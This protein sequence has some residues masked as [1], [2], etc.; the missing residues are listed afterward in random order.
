MLH[1]SVLA[2]RGLADIEWTTG[3]LD[4]AD[5]Q[6]ALAEELNPD[7]ARGADAAL[8]RARAEVAL[9]RNRPA[10]ALTIAQQATTLINQPATSFRTSSCSAS[11]ATLNWRSITTTMR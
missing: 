5:T 6:I 8:L 10:E 7:T 11:S 9:R 2:H 1:Y 3:N 4:E